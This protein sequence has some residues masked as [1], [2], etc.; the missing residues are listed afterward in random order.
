MNSYGLVIAAVTELVVT[1]VALL[2]GGRWLDSHFQTGS[3]YMVV[4]TIVG[5]IIGVMRMTLRLKGVMGSG[6][7]SDKS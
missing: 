3:R 1:V 7:S 5:F 2:F 6:E 4:G